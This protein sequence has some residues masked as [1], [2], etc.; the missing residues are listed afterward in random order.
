M[1]IIKEKPGKYSDNFYII[2]ATLYFNK[3]K[4][5]IPFA[6][7]IINN[8]YNSKNCCAE[9]KNIKTKLKYLTK[10]KIVIKGEK[11]YV[12]IIRKHLL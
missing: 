12:D 1:K 6:S 4:L 5:V 2:S 3:I 10:S 7:Q 11:A 9:C 8:R